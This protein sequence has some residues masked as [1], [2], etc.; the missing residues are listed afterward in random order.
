MQILFDQPRLVPSEGRCPNGAP[1]RQCVGWNQLSF[2]Q[3][4]ICGKPREC[5]ELKESGAATSVTA[6]CE[7]KWPAFG[8]WNDSR[9]IGSGWK[10]INP[11]WTQGAGV[12][13]AFE[14]EAGLSE[15]EGSPCPVN[16]VSAMGSQAGCRLE[17]GV[18]ILARNFM[19]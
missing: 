6:F 14:A 2:N 9:R 5:R 15:L 3:G 13:A 17:S 10:P 4:I 1:R 11:I 7:G 18:Q 8:R 16:R 19:K 12:G